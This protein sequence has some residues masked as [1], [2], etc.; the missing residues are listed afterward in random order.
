MKKQKMVVI[1]ALLML[2]I[3]LTG[4]GKSK[5]SGT[6]SSEDDTYS[7]SFTSNEECTWYQDGKFFNGTYEKIENG[8]QLEIMGDGFYSNT[9]FTAEMDG[10]DLVIT[11]G[12]VDKLRFIKE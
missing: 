6:Y 11:G 5:V 7:I 2:G 4:C 1:I 3:V 12:V 9:V 10:D 8:Y